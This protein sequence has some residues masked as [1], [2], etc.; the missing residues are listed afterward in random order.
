MKTTRLTR[1]LLICSILLGYYGH[2]SAQD[3]GEYTSDTK[4]STCGTFRCVATTI[5]EQ[6]IAG[7]QPTPTAAGEL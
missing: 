1:F 7:D 4:T 2:A 3:D 6:P 5:R